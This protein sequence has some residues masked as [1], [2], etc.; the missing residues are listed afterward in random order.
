MLA[1]KLHERPPQL[2]HLDDLFECAVSSMDVNLTPSFV[3]SH[4]PRD[5]LHERPSQCQLTLIL[6]LLQQARITGHLRPLLEHSEGEV[7]A[8]ACNVVGNLCRYNV[9]F[10]EPILEAGLIEVL[11]DRCRDY[12][13][14][15]RKFATFAIGNAGNAP[16]SQAHHALSPLNAINGTQIL[17]LQH[18]VHAFSLL[19]ISHNC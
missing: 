1:H 13:R 6:P 8:R 7:R 16:T 18:H 5:V 17:R 14:G 3:T 2:T 10:Y 12:D 9:T 15:T 19:W 4:L 11:I